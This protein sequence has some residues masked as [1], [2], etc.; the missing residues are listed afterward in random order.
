MTIK[1]YKSATT[2]QK[3]AR[4][5]NWNKA[6]IMG[7]RANV[8]GIYRSKTTNDNERKILGI[9]IDASN[10]IIQNWNK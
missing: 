3:S 7:I 8:N 4:E 9:I 6:L 1:K 5:R 10:E 2:A